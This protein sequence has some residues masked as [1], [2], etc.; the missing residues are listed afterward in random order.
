MSPC[1]SLLSS[2]L[3]HCKVQLQIPQPGK[4]NP[5]KSV[6]PHPTFLTWHP[7]V[8]PPT[9]L[10]HTISMLPLHQDPG[11]L[12]SSC[13]M[14][15]H[16]SLS[17]CSLLLLQRLTSNFLIPSLSISLSLSSSSVSPSSKTP[18][19]HCLLLES[20]SQHWWS[21][22]NPSL[23]IYVSFPVAYETWTAEMQWEQHSFSHRRND[24]K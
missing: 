16:F 20:P 21:L 22:S 2:N 24:V 8:S 11:F 3:H 14:L 17:S 1:H 19:T 18:P 12:S 23:C 6:L 10:P 7:S 4:P 15:H 5:Q 9:V 13:S